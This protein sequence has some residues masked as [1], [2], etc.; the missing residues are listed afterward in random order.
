LSRSNAGI[1][2]PDRREKAKN[3]SWGVAFVEVHS[4]ERTA[5]RTLGRTA[6]HC[7]VRRPA[8]L[9]STQCQCSVQLG[10]CPEDCKESSCYRQCLCLVG[11]DGIHH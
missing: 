4:N 11:I 5:C 7:S 3:R 9:F 10:R 8:V 6:G 1:D 2:L